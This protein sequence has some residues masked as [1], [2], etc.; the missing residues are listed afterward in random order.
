MF[1]GSPL[2]FL[3]KRMDFEFAPHVRGFANSETVSLGINAHAPHMWGFVREFVDLLVDTGFAPDVRGFI[4][5]RLNWKSSR[6]GCPA[7]SGVHLLVRRS[8]RSSTPNSEG[9]NA[10]HQEGTSEQTGL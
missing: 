8:W 6:S 9:S 10:H 5:N 2:D 4:L 3:S 7:R 1:G